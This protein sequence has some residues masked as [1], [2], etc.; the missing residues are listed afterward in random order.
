MTRLRVVFL[1]R[2]WARC[3]IRPL[4]RPRSR[5]CIQINQHRR[6]EDSSEQNRRSTL[7]AQKRDVAPVVFF[8]AAAIF[9]YLTATPGVLQ[10]AWDTYFAAPQQRRSQVISRLRASSLLL[11]CV[12]LV[13]MYSSCGVC[14]ALEE[15]G[16]DA[17]VC[18]LNK[19]IAVR[20]T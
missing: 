6:Y 12:S 2:V 14:V 13:V 3:A 4:V 19:P 11:V 1:C 10:G 17:S 16:H 20:R 5:I 18:C 15:D 7:E 8:G 9:A